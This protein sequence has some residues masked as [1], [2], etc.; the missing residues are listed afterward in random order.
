MPIPVPCLPESA[1]FSLAQRAWLNGFFAGLL[2]P[3]ESARSFSSA[4]D[5]AF[6]LESRQD[7]PAEPEET[8]PWHDPTLPME[9]RLKL[10][11]GR[12][13]ERVLM[14]AMAQLDCGA[15]GYV[16]KTYAEAIRTGAETELTRCVPGGKETA[17]KLKEILSSNDP[18]TPV[19][20]LASAGAPNGHSTRPGFA[21][22][23]ATKPS[24][25]TTLRPLGG[26]PAF[27]RKRPFHAP[28]LEN[29]PLNQPG[30]NKDTRHLV[31]DLDGSGLTYEVGDSLGVFPRNCPQV[32]E[33]IIEALGSRGDEEVD[34]PDKRRATLRQALQEDYAVN[35][36]S[37]KLV[38]LLAGSATAASG[39]ESLRQGIFGGRDACPLEELEVLDL[40]RQFPSARPPV[41]D[42][43]AVL[44]RLQP[45][46]YS[47]ASSPR[48]YPGQVHLTVAVVRYWHQGHLR[49]GVA[50]TF[51]AERVARG[52]KVPVFIQ[53]STKFRLPSNPDAPVIMV[54]PGT[55]IAPFR[56]FLQER[57]ATGARG[58]NWLFFGDQRKEFDFLYRSEL[59]Q[60]LHEGLLTRL[61]TAFSR[62][63][64][65]KVY[66][67]HRL[68]E[69]AQAVWNW[70]CEGAFLY[71]CGDA[72]RM[73]RDVEHTLQQ[74][75]ASRG[76]MPPEDAG[77]YLQELA[78]SH[79]YQRDVYS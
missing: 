31:L 71:V 63:Q 54:G 74:I 28:L 40:L 72:K 1:P 26:R 6:R 65:Q 56:A 50:S 44:P 30:S 2:C 19:V 35:R 73:A 15:C 33:G 5:N 57:R 68:L 4:G 14:A 39:G 13:L 53:P 8:F 29:R 77:A 12:P 10:A 49:R 42:F 64:E 38:A 24:N 17:R 60:L 3:E 62:D 20:V 7:K 52:Q 9:E 48:A 34:T 11:E 66:V 70:L 32:V 69:N 59:E 45:R 61:D 75:V 41:V 79:R 25:G 78:C 67:Q 23:A 37:E 47:I 76:Q 55:G 27:D 46:L 21:R 58:K 51:L 16:C 43:V 22:A 36:P 18:A